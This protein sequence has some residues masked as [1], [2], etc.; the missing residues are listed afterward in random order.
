[1]CAKGAP[2]HFQLA[3]KNYLN[4]KCPNRYIVRGGPCSWTPRSDFDGF[5][6]MWA[7]EKYCL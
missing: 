4:R 5:L 7:H 6:F 1:M 3:V 2:A